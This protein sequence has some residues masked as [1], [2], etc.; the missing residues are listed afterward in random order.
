M[1]F[2]QVLVYYKAHVEQD[3]TSLGVTK[4]KCWNFSMDVAAFLPFVG[5][6]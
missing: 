6:F 1:G 5:L 4:L 2:S 3:M